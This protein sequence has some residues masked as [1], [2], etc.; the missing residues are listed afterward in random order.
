MANLSIGVKSTAGWNV[1]LFCT[2]LASQ[3]LTM[4]LDFNIEH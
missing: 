2:N 4:G 1:S 3:P